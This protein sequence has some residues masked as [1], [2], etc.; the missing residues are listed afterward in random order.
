MNK[1]TLIF[2]SVNIPPV[3]IRQQTASLISTDWR[4]LT[5]NSGV[6]MYLADPYTNLPVDLPSMRLRLPANDDTNNGIEP[7]R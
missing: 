4:I 2:A 7:I 5:K 3:S 1:N 6:S